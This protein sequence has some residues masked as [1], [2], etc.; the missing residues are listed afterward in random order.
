M[1]AEIVGL[2]TKRRREDEK[3][4]VTK[5]PRMMEA[6]TLGAPPGSGAMGSRDAPPAAQNHAMNH[7]GNLPATVG[8]GEYEQPLME[9]VLQ[10]MRGL[11]LDVQGI[12]S[13]LYDSWEANPK[14][15]YVATGLELNDLWN[16][17]SLDRASRTRKDST[18]WTS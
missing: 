16:Q 18:R 12:K 13:A 15:N 5:N 4:E 10:G 9:A 14:S 8:E 17:E 1:D 6:G 7:M 2:T 11:V 3:E